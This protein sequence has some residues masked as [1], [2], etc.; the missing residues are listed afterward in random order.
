MI[1][2]TK[3]RMR[4]D[5]T[6]GAFDCPDAGQTAPKRTNSTTA[7]Q[8]LNLFNSPFMLQQAGFFAERI[9]KEA[10][11][12]SRAQIQRAF[13]LAYQREP[14]EAEIGEAKKLIEKHGLKAF[15]LALFNTNEFLFVF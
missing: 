1:Y 5:D 7:F 3:Q 6:F 14:Q 8:V 10:G 2:M 15:C 13:W 4:V 12:E 9:Q 11:K